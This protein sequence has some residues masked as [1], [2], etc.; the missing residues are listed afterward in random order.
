MAKARL[1]SRVFDSR[2]D[3]SILCR[4]CVGTELMGG[5]PTGIKRSAQVRGLPQAG[6]PL[7]ATP[8]TAYP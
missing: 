5:A 1:P 3:S 7:V 6:A 8:A 4:P 2:L